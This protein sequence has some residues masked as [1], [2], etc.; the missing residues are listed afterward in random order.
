L[1]PQIAQYTIDEQLQCKH[2]GALKRSKASLSFNDS[3]GLL[4]FKGL[5]I[6]PMKTDNDW[7]VSS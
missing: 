1:T 4:F 7:G 5:A 2:S 6:G 3:L